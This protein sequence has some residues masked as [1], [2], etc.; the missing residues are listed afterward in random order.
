MQVRVLS[1]LLGAKQLWHAELRRMTLECE[2]GP[3]ILVPG[4]HFILAGE[5]SLQ[6]TAPVA[7]RSGEMWVPLELLKEPAAG[8]SGYGLRWFEAER[9][10]LKRDQDSSLERAVLLSTQGP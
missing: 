5:R 2:G 3:V 1:V 4:S 8:F 7:L 9:V 10:V 6:L